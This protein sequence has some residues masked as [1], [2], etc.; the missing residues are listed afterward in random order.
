MARIE[1]SGPQVC[2]GMCGTIRGTRRWH[3]ELQLFCADRSTGSCPAIDCPVQPERAVC[4]NGQCD[5]EPSTDSTLFDA[6]RCLPAMQCDSWFGCA[7]VTGNNQNGWFV[8]QADK[9][10][11][12]E[13]VSIEQ[14]CSKP[15]SKCEAARVHS[16]GV[17]CPPHTVPPFI[18]PPPYTCAE[19]D[20]RCVA[21]PR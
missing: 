9:A 12:G 18:E 17:Q 20:G 10:K 5:S 4:K 14:V 8:R 21:T 2:C 6:H 15:D 16:V 7:A 13:I 11:R 1:A 3:A 19:K